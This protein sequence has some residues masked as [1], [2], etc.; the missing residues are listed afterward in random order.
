MS[1]K[2]TEAAM[3]ARLGIDVYIVKVTTFFLHYCLSIHFVRPWSTKNISWMQ[4]A[5]SHSLMALSGELRSNIPDDWLGT[6][7]RFVS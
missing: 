1:T 5:T 4:A 3:I 7:I 2:I 6:L